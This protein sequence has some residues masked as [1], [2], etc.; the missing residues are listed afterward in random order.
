MLQLVNVL[1]LLCISADLVYALWNYAK[2]TLTN[3]E[4]ADH[5]LFTT[6]IG[7]I[8]FLISIYL[9]RKA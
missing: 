3:Q 6:V 9:R 4:T 5:L 2:G 1:V 7:T 8:W